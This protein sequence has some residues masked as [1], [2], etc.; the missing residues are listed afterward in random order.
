MYLR[1]LSLL[2]AGCPW[3][4]LEPLVQHLRE[5]FDLLAKFPHLQQLSSGTVDLLFR[6]AQ[7]GLMPLQ[8]DGFE[9]VLRRFWFGP[10]PANFKSKTKTRATANHTGN[11]DP[12]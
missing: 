8:D 7:V 10:H 11:T 6:L 3:V 1:L 12:V 4:P 5:E 9:N 2:R